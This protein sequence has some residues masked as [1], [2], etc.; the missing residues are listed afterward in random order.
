MVLAH[1]APRGDRLAAVTES[2]LGRGG[3]LEAQR[4]AASPLAL[5]EFLPTQ[6]DEGPEIAPLFVDARQQA[7]RALVA[8][9]QLQQ[10]LQRL[11]GALGIAQLLERDLGDLA[12]QLDLPRLVAGVLAAAMR[13]W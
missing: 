8:R 6:R 9:R 3:E 5:V 12:Q 4:G 7:A 11:E 2:L 1:L 13:R 10:R